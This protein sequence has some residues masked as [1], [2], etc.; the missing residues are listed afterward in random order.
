[1]NNFPSIIRIRYL[2]HQRGGGTSLIPR[3]NG[4]INSLLRNEI[5]SNGFEYYYTYT[6]RRV[7]YFLFI[8][9]MD[10]SRL[11]VRTYDIII[12]HMRWCASYKTFDIIQYQ[13]RNGTLRPAGLRNG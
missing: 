3:L 4:V 6:V 11:I 5:R 7:T 10:Y 1:M 9:F 13:Y 12:I 2:L 8:M